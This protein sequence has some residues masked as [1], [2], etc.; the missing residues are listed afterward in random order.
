M[1]IEE[2]FARDNAKGKDFDNAYGNQCMDQANFYNR[3]VVGAPRLQGNAKD[4]WNTYPKDFYTKIAY[5]PGL[6][7]QKGDLIIWGTAVDVNGHIATAR[8]GNTQSFTSFDQNWPVGSICHFQTHTYN[9]VLGFLR[10]KVN[11]NSGG[12]EVNRRDVLNQ[13]YTGFYKTTAPTWW[14]DQKDAAGISFSDLIK[15]VYAGYVGD[16]GKGAFG[17]DMDPQ[18]IKDKS[19]IGGV[20]WG[21]E[22]RKALKEDLVIKGELKPN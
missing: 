11:L 9:G 13:I 1:T 14:I 4:V 10:P 2:Y 5:K 12:T 8:D 22:T 7:V 16:F 15:E 19:S 18:Y 17:H 20:Q 6:V 3:D 21:Q